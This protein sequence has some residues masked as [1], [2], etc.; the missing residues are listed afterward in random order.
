MI[1]IKSNTYPLYSACMQGKVY[2]NG[3]EY[4]LVT[5]IKWTDRTINAKEIEHKTYYF[6]NADE[7]V[8]R[9]QVNEEWCK[10]IF[11]NYPEYT[12]FTVKKEASAH[13]YNGI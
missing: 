2:G 10:N 12:K 5:I 1:T 4:E 13:V 11:E 9:N 7:T 6:H 8:K 3:T